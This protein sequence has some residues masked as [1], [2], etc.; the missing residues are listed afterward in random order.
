MFPSTPNL[1]SS[2]IVRAHVPRSYRTTG[3][4]Y[5]FLY[6][7]LFSLFWK[8][9][10]TYKFILLSVYVCMLQPIFTKRRMYI[11]GAWAHLNGVLTK[12]LPSVCMYVYPSVVA[13]QRLGKNVTAATNTHAPIEELLDASFS[14]RSM[15][16]Q[17]KVEI[18]SSQ[19]LLQFYAFR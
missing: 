16:C 7:S 12:Y 8:R 17:R 1:C 6:F 10:N 18:S 13:R 15:S 4:N 19:N 11:I 5:I 2:L 14:I 9:K 3:K